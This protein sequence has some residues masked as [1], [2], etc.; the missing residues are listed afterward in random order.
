MMFEEVRAHV[1]STA[2]W[3]EYWYG[4]QPL[5]HLGDHTMSSCCG[6][7]GPLGFALAV[8]PIVE[9]IKKEVLVLLINVWYLD[10]GT[11]CGSA[12]DML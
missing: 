4:A 9:R 11:L 3:M 12:E 8:H 2:A 6:V 10:S 7:L 1:P 5:L